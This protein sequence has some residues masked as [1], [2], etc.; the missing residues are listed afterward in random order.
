MSAIYCCENRDERPIVPDATEAVKSSSPEAMD[1]SEVTEMD[2]DKAAASAAVDPVE[3]GTE[4]NGDDS[5]FDKA[6]EDEQA[7]K[8]AEHG[9]ASKQ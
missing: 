2:A 6:V 1:R 3:G 7:A 4:S 8:T 5:S 9:I